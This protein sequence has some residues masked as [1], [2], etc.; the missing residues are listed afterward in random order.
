MDLPYPA[1]GIVLTSDKYRER[2]RLLAVYT[3]EYGKIRVI[4]R[5]S[6]KMNSKLSPHLEPLDYVNLMLVSG[7]ALVTLTGSSKIEDFRNL[8]T[9]GAYTLL[10]L[11]LVELVDKSVLENLPDEKIYNLILDL[12]KYLNTNGLLPAEQASPPVGGQAPHRRTKLK[13]QEI[14]LVFE[15][16]FLEFLGLR[17]VEIGKMPPEVFKILELDFPALESLDWH[18]V[19]KKELEKAIIHSFFDVLG[20][21]LVSFDK[22][23]R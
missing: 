1:Q 20:K 19:P 18:K 12:L 22:Y 17:P 5:G 3:K 23:I 8:K 15:L 11:Y 13:I 6:R 7:K 21:P 4:S 14:V 2:D 10:A 9:S 16:K